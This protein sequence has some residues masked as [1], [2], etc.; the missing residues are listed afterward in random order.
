MSLGLA[1][2]L[3]LAGSVEVRD[4]LVLWQH[5]A[6]RQIHPVGRLSFDGTRYQFRYVS[7]AKDAGMKPLLGFPSF[8]SLYES[9]ELPLLF[10]Q[11]IMEPSRPDFE[12]YVSELGLQRSATP[13]EQIVRT[14]GARQGDTIQVMELPA[15]VSGV[16]R[17][18]FFANGVRHIPERLRR[19]SGVSIS[20][21][22]DQ[23]EAALARLSPGE[24]LQLL[25]EDGNEVDSCA[26]L[27]AHDGTPLGYVPRVLSDS[28]R[29]LMKG[30]IVVRCATVG[31]PH[32][33]VHMRLVVELEAE[34]PPGFTFDPQGKW[35]FLT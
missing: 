35:E 27:L 25:P 2:R 34:A 28:V 15:V 10:S 3:D 7:G 6:T 14:G 12:G 13:W 26:T 18:R 1:D 8:E 24:L 16:A 5:P 21:T 9:V 11:R 32:V 17:A 4:L 22:R 30:Q 23:H 29:E 31:G 19:C 33:P 20:C